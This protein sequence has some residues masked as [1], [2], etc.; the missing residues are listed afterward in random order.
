MLCIDV[1]AEFPSNC[2]DVKDSFTDRPTDRQISY[3]FLWHRAFSKSCFG[4]SAVDNFALCEMM[5]YC[6]GTEIFKISVYLSS[7]WPY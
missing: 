1:V 2:F 6:S 5:A 3:R 7:T 4:T